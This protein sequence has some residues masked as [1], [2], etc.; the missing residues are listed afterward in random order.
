MKSFF[1][2]GEV[3]CCGYYVNSWDTDHKEKFGSEYGVRL[4]PWSSRRRTWIFIFADKATQDEWSSV[5]SS[6]CWRANAPRDENECIAS[7]FATTLQNLRWQYGMW[8]Y[9]YSWGTESE[10]LQDFIAC[11]IAEQVVDAV[12]ADIPIAFGYWTVSFVSV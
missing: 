10:R 1:I 4:S 2:I 12:F 6:A 7:A 11:A 3:N 8:G 9:Y 5:F